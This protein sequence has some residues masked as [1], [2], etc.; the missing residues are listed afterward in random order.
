[1]RDS[2]NY[3]SKHHSQAFTP[4][5]LHDSVEAWTQKL[6]TVLRNFMFESC[7]YS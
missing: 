7:W 4:L 5:C 6:Q 3:D 2:K 1:M